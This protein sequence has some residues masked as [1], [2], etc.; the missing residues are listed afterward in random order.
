AEIGVFLTA[1][2]MGGLVALGPVGYLSDRLG[3]RKTLAAV[4]TLTV[5]AVMLCYPLYHSAWLLVLASLTWNAAYR[6]ADALIQAMA[7]DT[8]LHAGVAT[9][10]ARVRLAG[11]VGWVLSLM[12]S[13]RVA[14]I[15]D[16]RTL[17]G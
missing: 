12:V 1:T 11:S 8:A 17:P 7:A 4:L 9:W 15:T 13:G 16:V 3:N 14:F 10:F 5:A 6:C 2:G